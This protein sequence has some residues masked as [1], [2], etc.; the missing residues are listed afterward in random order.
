MT[1]YPFLDATVVR[2][3]SRALVA[4]LMVMGLSTPMAEPAEV[5]AEPPPEAAQPSPDPPSEAA[6]AAEPESSPEPES[7][8][9]AEAE[10]TPIEA[11]PGDYRN[12][13]EVSVGGLI[14]D[15]DDAA[16]QRR[17]GLPSAPF[18]GVEQFHFERDVGERGLLKIDGRGIFD[19]EDYRLRIEYTDT[20][21]GFLRGGFDQTRHYYDGSGGW[22]PA[23]DLWFNLYDDQLELVR[24]AAFVEAGLRMANWPEITVR[25]SHAYRD[26][27]KD[28]TIWGGTGLTGAAGLRSIVPS[29][30][31]IDERSDTV[32]LEVQHT[33]GKTTYGGAFVFEH[34]ELDNSLNLRRQPF[35]ASDRHTTQK[36]RVERDVYSARAFVDTAL[37]PRLRLTTAYLFTTLDADFG[38]SRII[39]SDYDPVYD[40]VFARRDVGFLGLMGAS[41]VDQHVWNLNLLWTPLP[42][43]SVLPAFRLE[44]QSMDGHSAWMETGAADIAREAASSRDF[45]DLSQQ[46]EVRYTG[47][48]NTVLYARGDWVQGDGNIFEHQAVPAAADVELNR[49]SDFDRL[50][51]KYTA[52]AHWYPLRRL[53]LHAQYYHKIRDDRYAP[54]PAGYVNRSGLY[55]DFIREHDFVTDDVNVRV[56]W[57]PLDK[58]SLV[59]RYD[60]QQNTMDLEGAGAGSQRSGENTAHIISETITWTP[61]SRLYIQPGFSYVWDVT[62]SAAASGTAPLED[63]RND[64]FNVTCALGLVVDDRTDFQA[65]YSYYLADNFKDVSMQTQPYG[66]GTEEHGILASLVRR[67]SPR[68]RMTLRYGFFTSRNEL[69]GGFND[70]DAHLVY[71]SAQYLF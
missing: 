65:Q 38:G 40:P 70:Y 9:D 57:R 32:E 3:S 29:F 31:E 18:G 56:T 5:Q 39:G 44:N 69:A 6:P 50:S 11:A 43:L 67:I 66:S 33:I 12:W 41:Q 34:F 52:G 21:K 13:F 62:E 42:Y 71:T 4:G 49:D 20:E 17:L 59:S 8:P 7:E 51:Q 19:A 23:N 58:L 30:Q 16:A 45:L 53:N 63:A 22:F 46:I 37:D 35:E 55:P 36:E 28:S 64:Y 14:V 54:D 60:F 1:R 27:L 47:I 25:Y 26:G 15:G 2:S 10:E 24:G 68:L 48:T 61:I